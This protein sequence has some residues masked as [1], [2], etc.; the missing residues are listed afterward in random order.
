[1]KRLLLSGL[2]SL[3]LTPLMTKA[4]D[5]VWINNG[6]VNTPVIDAITVINNGTFTALSALPYET[7]DTLNFTNTGSMTANPG[8]LFDDSPANS[9]VRRPAAN[10][11]N[12][13]LGT[14]QGANFLLISATNIIN[15]GQF[16][17]SS[18]GL[19]QLQG[20]NL[21]LAQGVFNVAPVAA[22]GSSAIPGTNQFSADSAIYDQ[23]W[24]AT[25]FD[26]NNTLD[27]TNIWINGNQANAPF[28]PASPGSSGPIGGFSIGGSTL[29]ANSYSNALAFGPVTVTNKT[30][31]TATLNL[32]TNLNKGAVFVLAPPF[33]KV[34]TRFTPGVVSG[35]D[36][37]HV[38]LS[39]GVT[40][41]S[42]R[43]AGTDFVYFEDDLAGEPGRGLLVNSVTLSTSRPTNYLV[44]RLPHSQFFAP[45]VIV[46]PTNGIP[47]QTNPPT[48][49]VGLGKPE[50]NFFIDS[51]NQFRYPTNIDFDVVSNAVVNGGSYAAYSAF[52]D[53]VASR[54][55]SVTG[56]TITNLPGSIRI[57]AKNLDLRRARL[58]AE[59][60]IAI[61]AANL[62][63]STNAVIDCENLSYDIGSPGGD[64]MVQNLAS[65][66][67]QGR[68]RGSIFAWS[69]TWSNTVNVVILNN[70]D[71]NGV[72]IPLTNG[73]SMGYDVLI[74]DASGLTSTLSVNLYDLLMHGNHIVVN[75]D[76]T[77]LQSLFVD[78]RSFDIEGSI[79]IPGSFPPANPI[80]GVAFP[81]L[82]LQDWVFTNAPTL[83]FFT[84]NGTLS[85]P[86]NAHFGDDRP[87]PYLAF[88]N[89]GFISANSIQLNS[90]YFENSG[91]MFSRS[92]PTFI[93][94]GTG[95]L[96]GGAIVSSG[97]AQFNA[98]SL[99][100]N[101]YFLSAADSL[102]FSVTNSFSDGGPGSGNTFQ[103]QNGV[104]LLVKPRTGDLMGTTI[105]SI[106]TSPTDKTI[107]H[108][109]A[110]EDRGPTPAGFT[111]N[112]AVGQLILSAT[113]SLS[114]FRFIGTGGSGV[115]NAI[116][117]DLLDLRSLGQRYLTAL[118]ASPNMTI[119]YAAVKIQ[120][121]IFLPPSNLQE[122]EEVLDGQQLPNGGHLRWV[123]SFAG[124][125]SSTTVLVGGQPTQVN[126]A[127]QNSQLL[128]SNG[129]GTSNRFDTFPFSGASVSVA[130]SGNGTVSPNYNG[131]TLL[132]G[133]T[134]AMIAQPASGSKFTGWTGGMPTSSPEVVFVMP[135]NGLSL[136][137]HFVFAPMVASYNGLFFESNGVEF[138]KSGAITVTT[139]KTGKYSAS[140]QVGAKHY[141]VSGQ[142]DTSGTDN[143]AIPNSGLTL[144]LQAGSDQITGTV[145][146][147]GWTADLLANHAVFN[148]R[149]NKP[150]FAGKYTILF[151]GSRNPADVTNPQGDG[152]GSVTV[153][154]SGKV[155]LIGTL[156]DGT[157]IS[158]TTTASAGGQWPLYLPLYNGKG[159]ILSW[160]TFAAAGDLGGAFSWI[161][162]IANAKLYPNG[163]TFQTNA[164]G[165][166][167]DPSLKPITGFTDAVV[168]L[169]GGNLASPIV[170]QVMVT[171]K[172]KVVNLAGSKLT[173]TLTPAQ[174]LF[175]GSVLD[176]STGKP[177]SFSG[178][179]LQNLNAGSGFFLTTNLSGQVSFGP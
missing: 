67:I 21:D 151:P 84:N 9:G 36:D 5:A 141:S 58:R 65:P 102:S 125:N 39:L 143:K 46:N 175:K 146:G 48:G 179:I 28:V 174:G 177:I 15:K 42:T 128:D 22:R 26:A 159:Q 95:I 101:S 4:V 157:K 139:T 34:Q 77:V 136:V 6:T 54:P 150:S 164:I 50:N 147:A 178:A 75:D 27:T 116:Y 56:G 153:N 104:N 154:T 45:Q 108:Q 119:Y 97:L 142:L 135:T 76:V 35:F 118:D 20:D 172:N 66:T 152:Y 163:F 70:Y 168:L 99:T 63:S 123:S 8:W 149:T 29:V 111:N 137:A 87:T 91:F 127:L 38:L 103:A 88:V 89:S 115:K 17:V 171:S 12:D 122:A 47:I 37:I 167:F 3:T 155:H 165:S 106:T 68:L 162:P 7:A 86:N 124:P 93:Q 121:N 62:I 44:D 138:A 156:A 132:V 52:L 57:S 129:N 96:Q 130:V 55:P 100:V 176:A 166:P 1:M 13:N 133:Q 14:I 160:Q 74:L 16:S 2:L 161:K 23:Y 10:F 158:Q 110:G 134:Y 83:M 140:L 72:Q 113:N 24:G 144:Q 82:P 53:N 49:F 71:T 18:L 94:C 79:T 31:G 32:V 117:V 112:A 43:V 148:A 90:S 40:N 64:L 30:G 145:S 107:I 114:T 120:T 81:G 80:T 173:L 98:N 126:Q 109:W 92:R 41:S 131:Q 105:Q 73:I 169:T 33:M 69:A 61:Q 60:E 51:G 85:I 25:N 78:G 170:N 19:I 11:F 59:G